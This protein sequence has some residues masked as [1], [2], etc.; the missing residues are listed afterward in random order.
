MHTSMRMA[1]GALVLGAMLV[2]TGVA[3]AGRKEYRD[4]TVNVTERK[5]SGSLGD[6]RRN[7]T[8]QS[9]T[10]SIRGMANYMSGTAAFTDEDGHRG[11]CFTTDPKMVEALASVRSDGLVSVEWTSNGECIVVDAY[12][13]SRWSTKEQ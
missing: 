8:I 3:T 6:A 7:G 5:A 4:V 1:T 12:T 10:I 13:S 2:S 9:I 11:H